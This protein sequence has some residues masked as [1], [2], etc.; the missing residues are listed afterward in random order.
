M[1]AVERGEGT[2]LVVLHGFGWDHRVLPSLDAPVHAVGGWRRL[3]LAPP[4]RPGSPARDAASTREVV[5]AVEREIDARLG[6]EPFAVLGNSHGSVLARRVAHDLRRRVLGLA[7]LTGGA[8]AGPH[9]SPQHV[10]TSVDLRYTLEV[11]PEDAAPEP[12]TAPALFVA[13]RHDHVSGRSDPAARLTHYPRAT[14]AALDPTGYGG[15]PGRPG[16]AA[17]LVVDW[18][19]RVRAARSGPVAV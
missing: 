19:L 13:D 7:T 18:L 5:E 12:F 3:Y 14:F 6:D 9:R 4:G 2:P 8:V 17:A 15:D 16:P 10:E 11:E 1:H